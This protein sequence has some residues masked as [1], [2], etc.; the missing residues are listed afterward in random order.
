MDI[1]PY[2]IHHDIIKL[3]LGDAIE[4]MKSIPDE[5]IDMIFADLFNNV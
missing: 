5:S 4:I 3:Y 1:K 2:F